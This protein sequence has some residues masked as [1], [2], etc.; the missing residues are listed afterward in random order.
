MSEGKNLTFLHDS[1]DSDA[2][3]AMQDDPNAVVTT[4]TRFASNRKLPH[5]FEGEIK[6]NGDGTVDVSGYTPDGKPVT[7]HNLRV[8]NGC[9]VLPDEVFFPPSPGK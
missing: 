6:N 2:V 7:A 9:I 4:S 3:R 1:P 5:G 8:E